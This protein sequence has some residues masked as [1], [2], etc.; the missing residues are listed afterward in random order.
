MSILLPGFLHSAKFSR[1]WS[2]KKNAAPPPACLHQKYHR[3]SNFETHTSTCTHAKIFA[4]GRT[5][6]DHPSQ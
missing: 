1:S 5:S 4:H 6:H 2:L 3:Y